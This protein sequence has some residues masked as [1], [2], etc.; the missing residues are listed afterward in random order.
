MATPQGTRVSPTGK[1]VEPIP[2]SAARRVR[3]IMRLL[4]RLNVAVYRASKGR[5][6]GTFPGSG[7]PVCLVTFKGR[8]TGTERTIALIYVPRGEDVVLVA[9][10]GGMEKHPVWYYS[11]ADNPE[12]TR[13]EPVVVVLGLTQNYILDAWKPGNRFGDLSP[14]TP[15][16][17]HKAKGDWPGVWEAKIGTRRLPFTR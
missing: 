17:E 12:I 15:A 5:L 14:S 1:T 2:E 3:P 8:K 9:S 13:S 16:D 7:A 6:M 4:T 10:Q 11:I